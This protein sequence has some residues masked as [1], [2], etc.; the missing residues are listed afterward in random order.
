MPPS[1]AGSFGPDVMTDLAKS[2]HP[3]MHRILRGC[4]SPHSSSNQY[5]F[6]Q[7][8]WPGSF[9]D[10]D[11]SDASHSTLYWSETLSGP[12]SRTSWIA[13]VGWGGTSVCLALVN[14]LFPGAHRPRFAFGF[15]S[16]PAL[17]E[18]DMKHIVRESFPYLV[19]P[20]NRKAGLQFTT[21]GCSRPGAS[22]L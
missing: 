6:F 18:I 5:S 9:S 20:D 4:L 22:T 15:I 7:L 1:P 17:R 3:V 10:L 11:T 13:T 21:R 12:P 19:S 8:N 2:E 16:D 14:R